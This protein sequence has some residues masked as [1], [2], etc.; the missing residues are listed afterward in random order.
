VSVSMFMSMSISMDMNMYMYEY[1]WICRLINLEMI[2]G[3]YA[4]ILV[5]DPKRPVS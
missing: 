5:L 2:N 3:L 4:V 1:T